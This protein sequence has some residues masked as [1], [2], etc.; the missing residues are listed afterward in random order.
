MG[1]HK[2][3]I[4]AQ[5]GLS[6]GAGK[7]LPCKSPMKIQWASSDDP[8]PPWLVSWP[9]GQPVRTRS[10]APWAAAMPVLPMQHLP[11]SVHATTTRSRSA[12]RAACA[13]QRSQG[14][15][16]TT[17]PGSMARTSWSVWRTVQRG[18]GCPTRCKGGRSQREVVANGEG[19]EMSE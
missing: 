5:R 9:R 4:K 15:L 17:R 16:E 1:F 13:A 3:G 7:S 11:P 12:Q 14:R 19:D 10:T 8:T 18:T 6:A 2:E